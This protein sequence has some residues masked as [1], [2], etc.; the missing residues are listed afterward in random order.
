MDDFAE[1]LR[2]LMAKRGLGVRALAR[3]V[4]CDPAL[5]SRFANCRQRPSPEMA[6]HLDDVLEAGGELA[7]SL[8][9]RGVLKLGL[10]VSL[11]P[12]A[13]RL[14]LAEAA[15]EAVEFTQAASV[16][17]VGSGTF[18]HLDA[19]LAEL[20]RSYPV[21]PPAGLFPVARTYRAQ[22][23]RQIS[24]PATLTQKR[25]LY[26]Y[27]AWFSE[28]LAWLSH[29]LGAP[30][31]AHAWAV[32]CFEHARQAGHGELC[33]WAAD[34]MASIALYSGQPVRAIEA[35]E[36]GLAWVPASHP[37]GVRLR[38]QAARGHARLGERDACETLIAEAEREYE[39]LPDRPSVRAGGGG[40]L[41]AFA[42]TAYPASCYVWLG[43]FAKAAGYGRRAIEVHEFASPGERSPSREAIA[44][45][46][47]AIAVAGQGQPGEA[48]ELGCQALGSP[49]LTGSVLSRARD[50]DAA[51]VAR[52][53]GQ[54]DAIRF[55]EQYESVTRH[56]EITAKEADA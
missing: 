43:D 6:R 20:D 29:D 36:A 40:L 38:A 50:L 32:D 35:A 14:A 15:G 34:A 18:A 5:I 12:R 10:A 49:R 48:A 11:T 3:K 42:V 52:Y 47:L 26:V 24:G 27:A 1:Q 45:V 53:P 9:R 33:G 7:A 8:D 37:L 30:L 22:V 25:D 21:Q 4:P 39:S 54:A 55:R 2:A 41:A 16:T 56:R 44:R 51:L 46:D 19:V 23:Q 17:A 13:L 28:M 31:T